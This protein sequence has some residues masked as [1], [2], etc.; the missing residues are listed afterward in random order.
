MISPGDTRSVDTEEDPERVLG[1]SF[2]SLLAIVLHRGLHGKNSCIDFVFIKRLLATVT[3][4]VVTVLPT[5]FNLLLKLN[6]HSQYETVSCLSELIFE[7]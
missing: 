6:V 3:L 1:T 5:H 4:T 7:G 2:G